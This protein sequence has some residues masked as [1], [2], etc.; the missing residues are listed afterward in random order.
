M[1]LLPDVS[2]AR[3]GGWST[4]VQ[5]PP[6]TRPAEV[7]AADYAYGY[8]KN[9]IVT[10]AL[11]PESLITEN[12]IAAAT[13][14]SRTPVREAFSRLQ[15]EQLL[16]LIP[17]RGALVPEI[18]LRA[19]K[20]QAITRVVLEGYGI[21]WIC[22]H[23]VPVAER[24]NELVEQQHAVLQDDPERIVDMVSIDKEFHWTLVKATG[25]TEFAQLYNSIHDRQLR[26]G[27]AMFGAIKERRCAAVEQ[28]RDIAEAVKNFDLP[29]AKRL[30]HYHLIGG[31]HEVSDVFTN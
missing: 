9:L 28:H 22:E 2:R 13:G 27:I 30:L 21:E 12:E 29:E 1:N 20:E 6:G 25:N 7:K 18:T 5:L 8:L 3:F 11:P 23:K 26:I 24:L 17:H 10:L 14:V 16:I 31:M 4:K 15:S 19:I